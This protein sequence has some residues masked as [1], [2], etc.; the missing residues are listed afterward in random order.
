ME[1]HAFTD[2]LSDQVEIS[3]TSFYA[4]F[5]C[6]ELARDLKR[7]EPASI[8]R[9]KMTMATQT[10]AHTGPDHDHALE[11]KIKQFRELFADAPEIGKKALE[12]ALHELKSQASD[13][14]RSGAAY[15][16][17]SEDPAVAVTPP[18]LAHKLQTGAMRLAA[19][20]GARLLC[21]GGLNRSTQHP[22][23]LIRHV[24]MACIWRDMHGHGSCRS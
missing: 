24:G 3:P 4:E 10:Q 14:H 19:R 23:T 11:E 18:P 13:L 2:T 6:I 17:S 15:A 9:E 7:D 16:C 5:I 8:T 12:N 21:A 1:W 20:P 22:F